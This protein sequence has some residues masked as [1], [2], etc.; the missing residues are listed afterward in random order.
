[1]RK[2][3]ICYRRADAEYAAGALG[4]ELRAHFGE[5][6]VFRDK[7][8]IGGGDMWK[9][10]VLHEIDRQ[11]AL[12]VLIG[13]RWLETRDASGARRIDDPGDPIRMEVHDGIRDGATII[14]VLLENASMPAAADLPPEL[15]P[16]ADYN[17][18]KL[19]DSD[20]QYN[21][22]RILRTLEKAGFKPAPGRAPAGSPQAQA[23]VAPAASTTWSA[24]AIV[25]AVLVVLTLLGLAADDLDNDGHIGAAAI[26]LAALAAGIFA[27]R[28]TGAGGA[29]GRGL[30]IAVTTLAVVTLLASIGGLDYPEKT[31]V[32]PVDARTDDTPDTP[33]EPSRPAE[34]GVSPTNGGR[35]QAAVAGA[36]DRRA[37]ESSSGNAPLVVPEPGPPARQADIIRDVRDAPAQVP[38]L[39]GRW[40]DDEDSVFEFNQQGSIVHMTGVSTEGIVFQGAGTLTGRRLR[41][42][43]TMAGLFTLQLAVELS[44][45]GRRLEGTITG[46]EG[47]APV[48]LER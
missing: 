20:W 19:H 27:W 32:T 23:A 44:P 2:I 34:S 3:F 8:D 31:D 36:G 12:L 43:V 41:M 33:A 24:K 29:R 25:G 15:A 37:I 13:P 5:D 48:V 45:D 26:S 39:S 21:L 46:P 35:T 7:E 42:P 28:E 4:R 22:Q 47:A 30:A 6:Q 17:A 16:L 38:D 40:T 18:L 10:K 11:S 9:E 1:M 14:P